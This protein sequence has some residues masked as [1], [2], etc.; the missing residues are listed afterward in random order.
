MVEVLTERVSWLARR[1][2]SGVVSMAG[3]CSLRTSYEYG[4]V[5]APPGAMVF[6]CPETWGERTEK[7]CFLL[8]A[9]YFFH[10]RV[11]VSNH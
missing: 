11:H 8:N 2:L 1:A 5:M 9:E 6:F 4:L 7:S 3:R 10:H